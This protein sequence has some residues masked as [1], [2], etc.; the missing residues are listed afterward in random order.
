MQSIK[1]A[2]DVGERSKAVESSRGKW[3]RSTPRLLLTKVRKIVGY[4]TLQMNYTN[5]T[6]YNVDYHVWTSYHHYHNFCSLSTGTLVRQ[7]IS[8]VCILGIYL[9]SQFN[10]SKSFFD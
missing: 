10:N 2:L 1:Q 5:G 3:L 6:V 8:P 7:G 4:Q 9:V